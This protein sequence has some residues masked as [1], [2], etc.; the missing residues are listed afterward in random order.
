MFAKPASLVLLLA[1]FLQVA[2]GSFALSTA[3]PQA[4][5][6]RR[7]SSVSSVSSSTTTVSVFVQRWS[8]VRNEFSRCSNVFSSGASVEVAITSVKTLYQSCSTVANQ[9]S[10]CNGCASAAS[11]Q[12]VT[13]FRSSIE[14]S[15]QTW[16]QILTVGQQRYASVWKSQF[17]SVFQQFSTWVTAAK[18]ACSSFNLQLDVILKGLNL[19]LNLFL[20]VNINLSGLLGGVLGLVGGVLGGVG[21]LV[22]GLLGRRELELLE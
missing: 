5:I 22:G 18:T 3:G 6:A 15:F 9:Y 10:T 21:S 2:S 11:S 20:G 1:V 16:Q 17:A 7:Q 4:G 14:V 12:A 13:A 19:N 8:V